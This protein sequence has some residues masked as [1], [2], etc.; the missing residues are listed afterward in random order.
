MDKYFEQDDRTIPPTSPNDRQEL[1][2]SGMRSVANKVTDAVVQG[3]MNV[4]DYTPVRDT[5][6]KQQEFFKQGDAGRTLETDRA[7][8][9]ANFIDAITHGKGPQG[10]KDFTDMIV[11]A[12]GY[13][14]KQN[15]R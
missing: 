3:T 9:E 8:G 2:E 6:Q 11:A 4:T 12:S 13:K 5:A 10:Q 15:T 14:Y 1:F 7:H